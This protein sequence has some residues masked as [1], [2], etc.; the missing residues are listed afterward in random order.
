MGNP[1][2]TVV[3]G[4]EVGSLEE[5]SVCEKAEEWTHGRG[6]LELT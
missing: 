2:G 3:C 1:A 4:G 6:M 5:R